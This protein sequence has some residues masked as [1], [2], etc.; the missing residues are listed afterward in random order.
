MIW[1]NSSLTKLGKKRGERSLSETLAFVFGSVKVSSLPVW[2]LMALGL[3]GGPA[4]MKTGERFCLACLITGCL[5]LL[6]EKSLVCSLFDLRSRPITWSV[7][8]FRLF[9]YVFQD[10]LGKYQNTGGAW[11]IKRNYSIGIK[12]ESSACIVSGIET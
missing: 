1:A 2:C 6:E 11:E 9:H 12:G 10:S 7:P 5:F 3:L 8:S 4:L